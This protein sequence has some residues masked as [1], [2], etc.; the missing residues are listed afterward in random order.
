MVA[1]IRA[2][3]NGAEMQDNLT[4]ILRP[5]VF[6]S[7]VSNIDW[8]MCGFVQG[9][10]AGTSSRIFDK[11]FSVRFARQ[12]TQANPRPVRIT[13]PFGN[14][15]EELTEV[16]I[17]LEGLYLFRQNGNWDFPGGRDLF[18]AYA[19]CLERWSAE[20]LEG[21]R[22]YRGPRRHWDPTA[23]AVEMLMV[24]AAMAGKRPRKNSDDIG[25][26]NAIFADWPEQLPDKSQ[27]WQSL[28]A[29]ISRE[30][31]QLV[32]FVRAT[33]SG[34]KG[35]Q[36]GQF[37]DP[38]VL[39]P[40]TKRVRRLWELSGSP[41]DGLRDQQNTFGRFAR[42]DERIRTS[43]SA[44]ADVEWHQATD[45][46]ARWKDTFGM[47]ISGQK[48]VEEIRGLMDLALSSGT[49]FS[50]SDRQTLETAL[51]ELDAAQ[52]D[53]SL[54]RAY[55]LLE[56]DEPLRLLPVLAKG[57]PNFVGATVRR[58]MPA[59][60]RILDQLETRWQ[61]V[62]RPPVPWRANSAKTRRKSKLRLRR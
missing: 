26:L 22:A 19:N 46:A 47:E 24:G 59:L 16:A 11:A 43:L 3:G 23:A 18:V 40:A 51:A 61:L 2:W 15:Q 57:G 10:F 39:I 5:L 42:L 8:D 33:A 60:S 45:W 31:S 36:R 14:E 27:E 32:D 30:R 48:V 21:M 41:P 13:I 37:V 1:A 52:L 25:W 55:R 49:S 44:V 56:R 54:K 34:S 9:Y 17:A 4:G 53:E 20:V 50:P 38:T 12:M 6:D 28:Y 62:P 7:I 58:A 35:G 29:Y